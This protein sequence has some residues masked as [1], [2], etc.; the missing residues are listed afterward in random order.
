MDQTHLR[1]F[2]TKSIKRML[3]KACFVI[4]QED[5]RIA[6]G[7]KQHIFNQMTFGIFKEFLGFQILM[8]AR[9]KT[10]SAVS[11]VAK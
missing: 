6:V 2:T 3:N 7:P 9:K 11:Q 4:E 8:T 5:M 10:T 1:F